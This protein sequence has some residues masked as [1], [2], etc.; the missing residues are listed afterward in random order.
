MHRSIPERFLDI[1]I[2]CHSKLNSCA[3]VHWS[4]YISNSFQIQAGIRQNV[5]DV[6]M[7]WCVP[8]CVWCARVTGVV[9]VQLLSV[10]KRKLTDKTIYVTSRSGILISWWVSCHP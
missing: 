6:R 7:P 10:D 9:P 5:S 8:K 3:L 2:N 1:L 4:S